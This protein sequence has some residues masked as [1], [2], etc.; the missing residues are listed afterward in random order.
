MKKKNSVG[1]PSDGQIRIQKTVLVLQPVHFAV[2]KII[3][4]TG[5]KYTR[6]LNFLAIFGLKMYEKHLPKVSK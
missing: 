3:A 4:Q 5:W 1:R 6:A 2:E